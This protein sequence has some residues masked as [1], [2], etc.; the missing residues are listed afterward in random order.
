MEGKLYPLN[1]LPGIKRDGTSFAS[2]YW[3]NGK[4]MRFQRGLPRKIGGYKNINTNPGLDES[5]FRGL[6]IVNNSPNFNLYFGTRSSVKYFTIDIQGNSNQLTYMTG[7]ITQ[8]ANAITGAGTLFT[9]AMNGGTLVPAVGAPEIFTY[10]SPTTGTGSVSQAIAPGTAFTLF[11]SNLVDR[12][13]LGFDDNANNDWNFDS[14]FSTVDDGAILVAH[15]APNLASLDSALD[16]PVYYGPLLGPGSEARLIPAIA[17]ASSEVDP[18]EPILTSGGICVLHPFLFIFGNDGH[19]RWTAPNDPTNIAAEQRVTSEKIIAGFAT[20]GGNSSPAGLLWSLNTLIRV[21]FS[22]SVAGSD[23]T[24]DTVDSNC[25]ILS[26]N[27]IAD[28]NG[29]FVW[30]GVDNFLLYN[31]SVNTIPNTMNLDFFYDNLNFEHRAKVWAIKITE[32]NEIWWFFPK[33]NSA[34]CNHAVVYNYLENLWFDTPIVETLNGV[35]VE[36]F[37]TCGT[38]SP[39][40]GSAVFASSSSDPLGNK[41]WEQE[42]G[43]DINI[44]G[45]LSAIPCQI[46]SGD[47]SWCAVAPTGQFAGIDRQVDIQRFEPD[48]IMGADTDNTLTIVTKKYAQSPEVFSSAYPFS[49]DT[50]KIDL[51][52]QGREMSLLFASTEVG[53]DMQFGQNLVLL[54]TGDGRQ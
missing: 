28:F 54:R 10:L 13:P 6:F 48:F 35:E 2:R 1:F 40:F 24:F 15:A 31:G 46:Q 11:Y 22:P 26:A 23:F 52:I 33:G 4:W 3:Q 16:T 45:A 51:N 14:M 50:T 42:E 36:G 37:R 21:T 32:Y 34:E 20:R 30:P 53:G 27:C 25:S 47:I 8:A 39:M 49:S 17:S 29:I 7:T 43:V 5:D 9:A 44:A 18:G 19:V 41:I 38:F 12:T